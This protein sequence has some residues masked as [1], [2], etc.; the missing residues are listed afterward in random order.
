MFL[1]TYCQNNAFWAHHA[2]A[3]G[4]LS[5]NGLLD[6]C[7]IFFNDSSELLETIFDARAFHS[8]AVDYFRM[9]WTSV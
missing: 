4:G 7:L 2:G 8:L 5:A 3:R 6:I 1:L 9:Y